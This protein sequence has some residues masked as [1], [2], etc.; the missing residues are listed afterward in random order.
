M[1]YKNIRIPKRGGGTRLQRVQV[2]KSGKYKFVKNL[3]NAKRRVTSTVRSKS[4]SVSRRVSK[5]GGRKK[6]T[7]NMTL[8]LGTLSGLAAGFLINQ[9]SKS[10]LQNALSGDYENAVRRYIENMSG[11]DVKTGSWNPVKAK[12]LLA[13]VLGVSLSKY[14]GGKMG[15]NA[16][17]GRA[18]VPIVRV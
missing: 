16:R 6:T 3:K 9:N 7:R 5:K 2:L 10:P 12:G 15:V 4:R 1:V 18:G 14:V 13:L 11:L 8:P 17:L